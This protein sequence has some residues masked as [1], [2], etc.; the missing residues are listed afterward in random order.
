MHA[1]I[2]RVKSLLISLILLTSIYAHA[3]ITIQSFGGGSYFEQDANKN[4][5]IYGGMTGTTSAPPGLVT[6]FG[7][8]GDGSSTCNSCIDNTAPAKACNPASVYPGLTINITFVSDKPLTNAIVKIKTNSASAGASEATEY[9]ETPNGPFTGPAG[10]QFSVTLK[11]SYLCNN[12]NN[13]SGNCSPSNKVEST[14]NIADRKIYLYVDE[15]AD[16]DVDDDNEKESISVQLHYVDAVSTANTEQTFC[17]QADG[18]A[19]GSCGYLLGIGDSKFYLQEF[20]SA[21]SSGGVPAKLSGAPDWYGLALYASTAVSVSAMSSS[22]V[23]GARFQ[24]QRYNSTYGIDDNTIT[25]LVNYTNY[26]LLMGNINKAKNI[27]KFNMAGVDAAPINTCGQPSEVVGMLSDKSCFISTAAFGS[28][29]SDQVQ[30]LRQFRNEFLLTSEYGK[31]FVKAYYKLSPPIA[32]Y[33]EH[34]EFLKA[35]T[36]TALYPFV[37]MAWLAVNYGLLPVALLVFFVFLS[38]YF[39]LKKRRAVHV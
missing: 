5:T 8:T 10:T 7:C 12:D 2:I 33:I 17:K 34:S 39:V 1:E 18:T 30:L 21:V 38:L 32:H 16:G 6:T 22:H 25:G 27:Y 26:C 3:A 9:S 24:I 11:W 28:D 29:M 20:Y 4:F 35:M 15:N 19:L 37:L 31:M 36:R 23:D 13:F 14:F